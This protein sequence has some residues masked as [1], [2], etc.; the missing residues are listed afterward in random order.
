MLT[1][2][3]FY[4]ISITNSETPSME[5]LAIEKKTVEYVLTEKSLGKKAW[6]NRVYIIHHS[7]ENIQ[8]I[9]VHKRILK[10]HASGKNNLIK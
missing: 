6:C 2:K 7:Y 9:K 8:N 10:L 4:K 3:I 1:K 5:K